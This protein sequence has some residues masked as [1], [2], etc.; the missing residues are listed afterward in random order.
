[1][2]MREELLKLL[3]F[4]NNSTPHPPHQ[5]GL[6]LNSSPR[7]G[8]QCET[9]GISI[10]HALSGFSWKTDRKSSNLLSNFWGF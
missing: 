10:S 4:N 1:M 2:R 5:Q 8:V 3:Y 9:E 7:Y 6:Q